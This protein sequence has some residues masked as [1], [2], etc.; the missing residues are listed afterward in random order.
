MKSWSGWARAAVLMTLVFASSTTV[1]FSIPNPTLEELAR[2][3]D[4]VCKATVIDD[5]Q[6]T[7]N[8]FEASSDD[9]TEVHETKLRVVSIVKGSAPSV[10]WFRHYAPSSELPAYTRNLPIFAQPVPKSY[11]GVGVMNLPGT[12]GAQVKV[13][14]PGGPAEQAGLRVG[15]IIVAVDGKS[16]GDAEA[17]GPAVRNLPP[18][19]RVELRVLRDGKQLSLHVVT[20]TPADARAGLL[21][22][23]RGA[24]EDPFDTPWHG[25]SVTFAPGRTYLVFATQVAG[26]TYRELPR[27]LTWD[28]GVLL[29]ADAAPHRGTTVNEAVW[30]ELLT[31]LKSPEDADVI[32]AIYQLDRMSGGSQNRFPGTKDFDR[33][34]ARAAIQPLIRARSVKGATAAITVFGGDS[35]YFN[36]QDAPFWFAGIGKGNLTTFGPRKRLASPLAEVGTN[37]LL[38]VATDGMTPELRALAI[39]AHGRSRETPAAMVAAWSRD[40]SL[41]VRR[42]AVLASADLPDRQPITTASTDASPDLR[43][44][45]ALA[46]GFTQ[47]PHLLPLLD[48]LLHDPAAEVRGAAALSLFSFPIDQAAPVMKENLTSE[49]RPLYVNALA[50]GDPQPY[51]EMLAESIEQQAEN[52]SGSDFPSN[53]IWGGFSP[54][55][56]SWHILFDYVKSRPAAELTRGDFNRS[57]DALERGKFH[58]AGQPT[59]LYALYLSCGMLARAKQFR[60]TARKSSS[61]DIEHLFDGVDRDAAAGHAK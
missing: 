31:L 19:Q 29:A 52:P 35:P 50:R 34:Q 24:S 15:D 46:I 27:S 42:A 32:E 60:D 17:V 12:A 4:V 57:L 9:S 48:K 6:V 16:T 38:K 40:P 61:F 36:D 1:A 10:I 26:D 2:N 53:W 3:A 7:D 39:R 8:S 21:R 30:A 49:F 13:L 25:A 44:T 14:V 43:N 54:P 41:A 11:F 55:S 23:L 22:M 18:G 5:R 56:D 51:L 45:T 28:H 20:G 59:S 47:D 37:E 58:N 33:S